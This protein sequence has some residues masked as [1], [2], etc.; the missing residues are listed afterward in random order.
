MTSQLKLLL[1]P[2]LGNPLINLAS[3]GAS[4]LRLKAHI[5]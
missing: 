1:V 4:A 3:A 2:L 5:Q